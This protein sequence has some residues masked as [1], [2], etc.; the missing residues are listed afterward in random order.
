MEHIMERVQFLEESNQ[1]VGWA[2]LLG[3]GPPPDPHPHPKPRT[4]P[5][6]H[7]GTRCTPRA[8]QHHFEPKQAPL[9]QY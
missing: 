8:T 1:C 4:R 2:S 9:R 6:K 5:A 3:A 7:R